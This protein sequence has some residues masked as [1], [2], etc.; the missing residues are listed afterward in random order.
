MA[1]LGHNESPD[2]IDRAINAVMRFPPVIRKIHREIFDRGQRKIGIDLGHHHVMIMRV[3]QEYGMLSSSELASMIFASN[4]QI[5]HSTEK[6]MYMGLVDKQSDTID[7]RKVNIRLT[8]KGQATV[9]KIDEALLDLLRER[10]S[11]LSND[12]LEKLSES[13]DNITDVFSS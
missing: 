7:R 3:L 8:P 13:F 4:A 2:S 1:N 10:L 9:Q 5:T 11:S 12:D 6:L